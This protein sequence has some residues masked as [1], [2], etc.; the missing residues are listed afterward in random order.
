MRFVPLR[1]AL[2]CIGGLGRNH[3][4]PK[5][6]LIASIAF[7]PV[8]L[9]IFAIDAIEFPL[10]P[11]RRVVVLALFGGPVRGGGFLHVGSKGNSPAGSATCSRKPAIIP[12]MWRAS[13][14]EKHTLHPTPARH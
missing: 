1:A 5:L 11:H 14:E 4:M 2:T 3:A 8:A 10:E 12:L 7:L 6:G 13:P 9:C